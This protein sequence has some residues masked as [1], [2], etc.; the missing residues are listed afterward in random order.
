MWTTSFAIPNPDDY[1]ET[2]FLYTSDHGETLLD[3][4]V[5]WLHCGPTKSETT[6]PLLLISQQDYAVD[7]D[8][9]ASH[10]NIFA[11]L[12]DLMQFPQSERLYQYPLSLFAAKA[13]D[14]TDRYFL[15]GNS[16]LINYDGQ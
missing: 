16:N 5:P 7:T 8:Y 6:V 2:T 1:G 15:D 11:T 3:G 10:Y 9:K 12:L 14:S 4:G 13:T